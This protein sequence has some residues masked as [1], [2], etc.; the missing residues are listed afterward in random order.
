MSTLITIADLKAQAKV[1]RAVLAERGIS[2]NHNS[3]L[4]EVARQ[5]GFKD[6]RAAKATL[7]AGTGVVDWNRPFFPEYIEWVENQDWIAVSDP[8][9]RHGLPGSIGWR[10][11]DLFHIDLV[12]KDVG[13]TTMVLL[14]P[15]RFDDSP[16]LPPITTS[17][18]AFNL[19]F[20][21]YGGVWGAS[22]MKWAVSDGQ[23]RLLMALQ[24]R[25]GLT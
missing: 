15:F 11:G 20:R 9:L 5:R 17:F 21:K 7:E 19:G 23:V 2:K 4:E 14:H 13:A 3:C 12:D 6:F 22:E 1:L 25:G 16:R 18:E 24:D 10:V 8:Y